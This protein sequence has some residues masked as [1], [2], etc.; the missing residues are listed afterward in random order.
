MEELKKYKWYVLL[1]IVIGIGGL[2]YFFMGEEE[3]PDSVFPIPIEENPIISE[4]STIFVD[5]KGAV[6]KEGVYVLEEGDRVKDA[7]ELA[8]GFLTD[9]N[10][11]LINLA[12]ILSDE[13]LLYV[14][15]QSEEVV[16]GPNNASIDDGKINLN[17]A[18]QSELETL[19]GIG[20]SKAIAIIDYRETNG[21]FKTIEDL[22]NIGGIG[23]KT[24]EKLKEHIKIK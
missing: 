12:Q 8:G 16:G 23:E 4:P 13:M 6:V 20:P 21:G 17:T 15:F 14:P 3:V 10:K 18:S 22:K 7:I 11:N 24:F 9:A 1:A 5:V 19:P 2:V